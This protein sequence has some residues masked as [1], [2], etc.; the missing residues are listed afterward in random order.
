MRVL[1]GGVPTAIRT[2]CCIFHLGLQMCCKILSC[3]KHLVVTC[4]IGNASWRF[5]I[6]FLISS[7]LFDHTMKDSFYF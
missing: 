2:L 1:S 3:T 4:T 6:Y 7:E 5:F